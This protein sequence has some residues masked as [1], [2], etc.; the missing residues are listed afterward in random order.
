MIA[1]NIAK[2]PKAKKAR[3]ASPIVSMRPSVNTIVKPITPIIQTAKT[4][5]VPNIVRMQ[6]II[7]LIARTMRVVLET[8]AANMPTMRILAPNSIAHNTVAPWIPAAVNP[9]TIANNIV[10]NIPAAT[11]QLA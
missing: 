10:P 1:L 3:L 11:I 4:L 7:V 5:F 2:K 9:S 8:N 6:P